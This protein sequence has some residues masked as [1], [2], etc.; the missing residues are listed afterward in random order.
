MNLTMLRLGTLMKHTKLRLKALMKTAELKRMVK[1]VMLR[2]EM[3]WKIRIPRLH[4]RRSIRL[5]LKMV[6]MRAYPRIPTAPLYGR[7]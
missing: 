3:K 2:P 6:I 5:I 4:M 7:K 1:T